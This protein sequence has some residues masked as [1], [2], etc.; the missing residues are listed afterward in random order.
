MKPLG[1]WRGAQAVA[2]APD[3]ARAA[4]P[5]CWLRF[6][7]PQALLDPLGS[8][9]SISAACPAINKLLP[10]LS[11]SRDVIEVRSEKKREKNRE[12]NEHM[13]TKPFTSNCYGQTD[14]PSTHEENSWNQK[15]RIHVRMLNSTPAF[16]FRTYREELSRF[17]VLASGS[18][19]KCYVTH[20]PR[21]TCPRACHDSHRARRVGWSAPAPHSSA[22]RPASSTASCC[23][24]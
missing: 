13:V 5:L 17:A 3:A 24:T 23:G 6:S 18:E 14:K 11:F 19:L 21:P 16:C 1:I 8:F 7:S 10:L 20:S 12:N 4:V 22:C 2:R 9:W 15:R